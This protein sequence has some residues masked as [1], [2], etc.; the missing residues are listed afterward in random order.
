MW[1]TVF[2]SIECYSM[3]ELAQHG[4][5]VLAVNIIKY[6]KLTKDFAMS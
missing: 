3:F 5:T 2:Q 1:F 4:A 6:I